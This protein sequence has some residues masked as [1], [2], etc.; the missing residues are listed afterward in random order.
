[1]TS[2]D[3][4]DEAFGALDEPWRVALAEA[5][6]SWAAGSA[7]VGAVVS[8]ADGNIVTT[9]RNRILEPR[10]EPGVLASTF[11]AHA[12]MNALAV[13]PV[14][15]AGDK[16][17]TTTY[18][19]C[20]MCASTIV[21]MHLPRVRYAAA[22]PV[23]D[24]LHDWFST[25]PFA[26]TR[27]PEREELG[28]PIGAFAHVLHVSWL[29]FFG[30]NS[31]IIDAHR[32]LKPAHLDLA[33]EIVRDQHLENVARGGGTVVDALRVLWPAVNVLPMRR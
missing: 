19:P 28:G 4:A 10:R 31:D 26:K 6:T 13:L 29:S 23:F 9:G 16:T 7:G 3:E 14:G 24:G 30:A 15:P 8:D 1:M 12:E 33:R 20:L 22:D 32:S 18:E 25:L 11:L 2:A 5:W 17:I 21:Q 27:L